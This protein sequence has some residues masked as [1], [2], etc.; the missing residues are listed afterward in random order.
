VKTLIA[1]LA[2]LPAAAAAGPYDQPWAMI[3][4]DP[5]LSARDANLRPAGVS[6]V[7]GRITAHDRAVV[8]PGPH[9]VTVDLPPPK[10]QSL[11]TRETLDVLASPCMRYHVAA[12]L[13]D[14]AAERWAAVVRRSEL[15]GE[16]ATKFKSDRHDR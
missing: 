4:S 9:R 3:A 7:D 16:C 14:P 6:R 15:I 5:E 8:A 12:R 11:G 2:L 10:G 13:A 1:A